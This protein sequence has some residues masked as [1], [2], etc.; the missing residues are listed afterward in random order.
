MK[1]AGEIEA[2]VL[3]SRNLKG[4]QRTQSFDSLFQAVS[5]NYSLYPNQIFVAA[6]GIVVRSVA[7]LIRTKDVDPAVVVLDHEGQFVVSLLS[8]HLGGANAL[9]RQVAGITQG[10]AVITTATDVEGLKAIDVLVGEKGMN[11]ANIGAIKTINSALLQHQWISVC[12]PEDWLQSE[13]LDFPE[14]QIRSVAS[15]DQI[16][17]ETPGIMVTWE[18][19]DVSA[20]TSILVVR[21]RCL[22]LGL[23]CNRN[24]SSSE[25]MDLIVRTFAA[26]TLSLE[27]IFCLATTTRKSSEPG[28]C[29][30]AEQLGVPLMSIP[31]ALLPTVSVPNPS[32]VVANY[33][34]VPSV[35]EA[36]ALIQAKTDK[37]LV[38]KTKS[39]NVTLAV[40]LKH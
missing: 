2:D 39:S 14:Y 26:Y 19:M 25:V 17:S 8:G 27:S 23:G 5:A 34:G 1:I 36:A 12:D 33:M 24:T 11:L 10:Q 31:H 18:A 13:L 37:L 4:F 32:R 30:T 20:W 40:A 15:L 16:P 38:H 3:I 9:A 28:L 29:Q 35:C 21:P 22:V 7:P 6:A